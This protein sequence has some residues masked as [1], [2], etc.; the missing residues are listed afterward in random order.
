MYSRFFINPKSKNTQIIEII[1]GS[2]VRAYR[3]PQEILLTVL[4]KLA[5][6]L[7]HRQ[8]ERRQGD[9]WQA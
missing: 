8:S 6:R 2:I 3:L 4:L 5:D 7:L 9:R 1:E